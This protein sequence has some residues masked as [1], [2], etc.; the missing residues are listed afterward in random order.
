MAIKER[1]KEKFVSSMSVKYRSK[2][3]ETGCLDSGCK[4]LTCYIGI[5]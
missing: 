1:D 4:I 2:L 5:I 3:D